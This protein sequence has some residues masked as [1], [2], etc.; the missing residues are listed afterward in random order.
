M[1]VLKYILYPFSF[2]YGI[3]VTVRNLFFDIGIL[4]SQRFP[5]WVI[6][7][8]NLS[9]GGTGKS[10]HTEYIARLLENLSNHYENLELSFDKIATLSRGYGRINKGF[11]LVHSTS[12]AKEVG[13]EPLQLKRRLND[14]HVAVDE[15]RAHGINML[16]A[17]NPQLRVVLLDD[18]FQ[19]RYVNRDLSILLT[20]YNAPF[21]ND[22]ML[23]AGRL[24]EPRRGYKRAQ[25]IIVTN[26]PTSIT[27]TEKKIIQKS[28]NPKRKQKVFF[29]SI[30][31]QPLVHVFKSNTPIPPMDKNHSV[32]LLTGIANAHGLYNY[33]AEIARDV[34]HIPFPDHHVFNP[35]DIAKVIKSFDDIS[36]PNKIII[37]TEK[38]AM[39]LQ[40]GSLINGFG[41]VTVFYLPIQVKI[42]EENDFEGAIISSLIPLDKIKPLRKS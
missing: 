22:C 1:K 8:G 6:S 31:Y 21:Y 20:N 14:L 33:L 19:H 2:L 12:D 13:D 23:P 36:N 29:S 3:I 9:V 38:D 42:H 35:S 41:K 28:I 25:L 37:T 40:S 18:A 4:R 10:P 39:R 30:V 26:V 24:R 17:S 27:D 34:I 5:L 7:I 32:L 15:N 16:L 11:K